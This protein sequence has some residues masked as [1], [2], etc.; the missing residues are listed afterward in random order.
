MNAFLSITDRRSR[1]PC[2]FSVRK[3]DRTTDP[4]PQTHS[5]E[6]SSDITPKLRN[7]HPPHKVLD[8]WSNHTTSPPPLY[9]AYPL[10]SRHPM[11]FQRSSIDMLEHVAEVK[12]VS[13]LASDVKAALS[14]MS[15]RHTASTSKQS[16]PAFPAR[17]KHLCVPS[18][19]LVLRHPGQSG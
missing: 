17:S 13:S 18:Y 15:K 16:I 10:R 19:A 8:S 3:R 11:L 14:Y 7:P 1:L 6:S 2:S 4:D 9:T 5:K 12:A